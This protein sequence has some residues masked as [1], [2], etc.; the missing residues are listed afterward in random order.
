VSG[1]TTVNVE[2]WS[3]PSGYTCPDTGTWPPFC[4]WPTNNPNDRSCGG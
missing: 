3:C 1:S 4:I 2:P